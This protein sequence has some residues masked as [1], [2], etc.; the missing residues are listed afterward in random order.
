MAMDSID[1][2]QA[3][4]FSD[5]LHVRA[6]QKMS[7]F[8]PLCEVRKMTGD[9]WA[10]D[11]LGTV[12]ARKLTGRF[13]T[14]HFSDIEHN[15]RKM[16][17]DRFEV[18]IPIDEYDLLGAVTD[19]QGKYVDAI[20]AAMERQMDATIYEAMFATVYT[21]RDMDTAVTASSDGVLTVNATGGLTLAK[22]LELQQNWIDGEVD[23]LK[24]KSLAISGDENTT[25]LQIAQLTSGDY[26]RELTLEKGK[27]TNAV[28]LDIIHF[29]AN[30]TRPILGVSGGVRTNAAL[31]EGGVCVGISKEFSVKI[32]PRPDYVDTSQIQ[33]TGI[34][35]AVRTEG[36]LVQKFTTTD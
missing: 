11:G 29:G 34:I 12:E 30:S 8:R 5:S 32:Q 19:P 25:M 28:G 1:N 31:A 7:R 21:G 14:T 4:E 9:V 17:R 24:R 16:S 6:Q 3:I 22:L 35:G 18:T 23:D 36:K 10:Y 27:I 15:R 33:V 26:R 2:L 20:V 13:N